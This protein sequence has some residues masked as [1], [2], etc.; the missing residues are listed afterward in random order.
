MAAHWTIGFSLAGGGA[1]SVDGRTKRNI[2]HIWK[3]KTG[4]G[5]NIQRTIMSSSQ[6][7][8]VTILDWTSSFKLAMLVKASSPCRAIVVITK[9]RVSLRRRRRTYLVLEQLACALLDEADKGGD[10]GVDQPAGGH[11]VRKRR[12]GGGRR[13]L[14][15]E[16]GAGWW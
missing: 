6:P 11:R 13:T 2:S 10:E 15:A 4:S 12:R 16:T 3:K 5:G 1:R 14:L 9:G 7:P 8:S